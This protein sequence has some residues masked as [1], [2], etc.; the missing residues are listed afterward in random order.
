ML[1]LITA[2]AARSLD[3]D[4]PPLCAAL[5]A[6][7]IDHEVVDWD[8]PV[9]DWRRYRA[10][11][12]RSTWDYI[13]RFDEFNAW[14][15][16]IQSLTRLLNPP[17]VVRWNTHKGYLLELSA[18]G[19]PIVPTTLIRVGEAIALPTADELVV[20]P[21]VGAGS[22][23]ARRFRNDLPGATAHAQALL[24]EG[25]DVLLQPYLARVDQAGETALLYFGGNYSHAIRKGPLLAPNADATAAL[26]AP[27]QIVAREPGDDER[28]L[29]DQVLAA[30][31]FAEP[32][33]YARV[34]LLRSE[35]GA[36]VLLELELTEPSL[37]FA[38]AP[39]SVE[40]YVDTLLAMLGP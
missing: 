20:K 22:R 5:S 25:R 14:I 11:I 38:Y 32:L 19:V 36:P 21:A 1:A 2:A 28:A 23:G 17:D 34:D 4:L 31:P 15:D 13:D 8:D 27:E 29:A 7:G 9:V 3:E 35:D 26:F 33:L 16:R 10:A 30:L 37:F 12:L 6:R 24:A 18:R 39:G 40:R